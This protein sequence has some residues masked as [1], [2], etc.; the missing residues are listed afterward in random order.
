MEALLL[1]GGVLLLISLAVLTL[2]RRETPLARRAWRWAVVA[3]LVLVGVLVG[4]GRAR[5]REHDAAAV[6]S[7]AVQHPGVQSQAEFWKANREALGVPAA[8]TLLCD[9]QWQTF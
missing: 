1:V 8:I 9:G 3:L 4:W 5:L 6:A 2:V 7:L